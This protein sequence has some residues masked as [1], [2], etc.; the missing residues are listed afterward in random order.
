VRTSWRDRIAPLHAKLTLVAVALMAA[1]GLVLG[2]ASMR[3]AEHV[4]LEATQRLNLNLARDIVKHQPRALVD[5]D[6]RADDALVG[7]VAM[8]VMT[9]NPAVE[10]YVLDSAGR[11]LA[12]ALEGP[13]P[14][15][16]HVDLD[17]VRSLL[18]PDG[19]A[20]LPVLGDD[21]R[22][23]GRSTVVSL[24][25]I[26]P[27]PA[28][29]G[30][31]TA[32]SEAR[33]PRGYVY[34]VLQGMDHQA[35]SVARDS[36]SAA[37]RRGAAGIALVL[38]G[39]ALVFAL[40]LTRLTRPLRRLAD[41]VESFRRDAGQ[42]D[43]QVRDPARV[44]GGDEVERLARATQAMRERIAD[45]FRRLEDNDR[46]RREL[47]GNISH[48]LHTPLASVQGYLETVLLRGDALDAVAR[49]QHL[50]IALAHARRLDRRIADLFEL[51]KLDAGRVE[52]RREPFCLAELLQDVVQAYRLQ[53]QQRGMTIEL[54][55][56]AHAHAFVVADIALIERVLQNL[57]DN[58]L[59]YTPSGGTVRLSVREDDERTL[60]P[61][62][63]E[64]HAA[65]SASSERPAAGAEAGR[66]LVLAVSDT[67]RGIAPEHLPY[68]FERYWRA[69]DARAGDAPSRS[70]G[71][72]LAIVKRIVELH[73]S[74]VRVHSVPRQ[75][76]T[77]EFAL[78]RAA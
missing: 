33:N 37:L 73:G 70:A 66:P 50:R 30:V 6:G 14:R 65:A 56:G 77:F 38:L 13:Q 15:A 8:M 74:V 22:Q 76:T 49:E 63:Q 52:P 35:A 42:P 19:P 54:D 25:P 53:A 7:D 44:P 11:I 46:M 17:R 51:S 23:P 78:P 69:E 12:H 2:M 45:Q 18:A 62:A 60:L 5:A 57:V 39:A 31:G 64:E 4:A 16:T 21:P 71:L 34:V 68:V 59:H 32:A 67:G 29:S 75:G 61:A 55:A 40:T 43:A 72:G 47:I 28:A 3:H 20:M 48:D 24:A 58:A 27:A 26:D 10:V 9:I 36:A 1:A 41:E